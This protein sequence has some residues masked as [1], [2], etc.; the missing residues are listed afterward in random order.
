[1]SFFNTSQGGKVF[2]ASVIRITPGLVLIFWTV[3]DV[4]D[5]VFPFTLGARMLRSN[6]FFHT[7]FN[8]KY[9][10]T[11]HVF[12]E[13]IFALTLNFSPFF[14]FSSFQFIF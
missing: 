2:Q 10:F 14:S 4:L 1:M 6:F 12:G 7:S 5:Y 13:L 3:H 11:K 8:K 9:I